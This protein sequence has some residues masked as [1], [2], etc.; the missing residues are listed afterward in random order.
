MI[1]NITSSSGIIGSFVFGFVFVDYLL[2]YTISK[3]YLK[4]ERLHRYRIFFSCLGTII[5]GIIMLPLM[6]KNIIEI[7]S[8]IWSILLQPFGTDRISLT[9][10]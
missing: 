10:G 9:V 3:G 7:L 2:Y 6:G 5:L 4:D 1:G 8:R